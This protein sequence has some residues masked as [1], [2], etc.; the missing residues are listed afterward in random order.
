MFAAR[1]ALL[2]VW[3][4]PEKS[5]FLDAA[6][7]N[8][9]Q[10]FDTQHAKM[11]VPVFFGVNVPIETNVVTRN[12][13]SHLLCVVSSVKAKTLHVDAACTCACRRASLV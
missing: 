3:M 4:G 8:E 2:L 9:F 6:S 13:K 12:A 1:I 5:R 11:C 7:K 10:R